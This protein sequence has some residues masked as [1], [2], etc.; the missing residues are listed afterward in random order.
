MTKLFQLL[1]LRLFKFIILHLFFLIF[2]SGQLKAENNKHQCLK[3]SDFNSKSDEFVL[4]HKILVKI[5]ENKKFQVNNLKILTS[6][7]L[8]KKKI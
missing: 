2:L 4:P 3:N 7:D 1:I 5:N 8:I 6:T